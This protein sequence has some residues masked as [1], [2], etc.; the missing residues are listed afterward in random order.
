MITVNLLSNRELRNVR[1]ALERIYGGTGFVAVEIGGEAPY[2]WIRYHDPDKMHWKD[3]ARLPAT[4]TTA[5]VLMEVAVTCIEQV[6]RS[7][8]EAAE[9]HY[10][11]LIRRGL[12]TDGIPEPA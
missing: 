4:G 1:Q 5:P 7:W 3:V 10:A 8:R 9:Q 12:V 2:L 11:A 6:R